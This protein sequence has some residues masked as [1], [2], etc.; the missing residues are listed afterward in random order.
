M[1]A[2]ENRSSPEALRGS[3]AAS[4]TPQARSDSPALRASG[5]PSPYSPKVAGYARGPFIEPAL[6]TPTT[7]RWEGVPTFIIRSEDG[8]DYRCVRVAS[9][10]KFVGYWAVER[11]GEPLTLPE[12]E[13]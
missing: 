5:L 13:H 10:S 1:A 3:V 8:H 9:R 4:T 2:T 12:L 7:W 6:V 11:L